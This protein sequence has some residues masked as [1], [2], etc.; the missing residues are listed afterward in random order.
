MRRQNERDSVT[1]IESIP[2]TYFS[3]PN[4]LPSGQ[5]RK[6]TFRGKILIVEDDKD[7]REIIKPYLEKEGYQILEAKNGEEG[8]NTL[9]KDDNM[10]QVSLILCD[11]RMPVIN[12]MDF[13]KYLQQLAPDINVIVIT[14]YPNM[15]LAHD[16]KAL[17]VK[18]FLV[19]PFEKQ[20]LLKAHFIF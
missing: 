15:R 18:E 7:V 4:H 12:G 8:I 6:T 3:T 1:A 11:L 16:L 10:V 9:L 2:S 5:L 17:G 14:G 20:V 19:K 13:I